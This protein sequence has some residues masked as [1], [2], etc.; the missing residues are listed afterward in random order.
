MNSPVIVGEDGAGVA[1]QATGFEFGVDPN[2]DPELALVRLFYFLLGLNKK[3]Y[4]ILGTL[5][6][7][8]LNYDE[9][10]SFSEALLLILDVNSFTY[11][12]EWMF[13]SVSSE[14]DITEL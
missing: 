5:E 13:D 3:K 7:I 4:T 1:M 12:D 10:L 6:I 2:E 9:I 11:T 8:F 14:H